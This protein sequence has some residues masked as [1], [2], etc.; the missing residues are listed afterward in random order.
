MG[1]RVVSTVGVPPGHRIGR[2]NGTM[3]ARVQPCSPPGR[4]SSI[5]ARLV[6]SEFCA[7]R[8]TT[9]VALYNG[10]VCMISNMHYFD[11]RPDYRELLTILAQPSHQPRVV[12]YVPITTDISAHCVCFLCAITNTT[13]YYLVFFLRS[14]LVTLLFSRLGC[15][16]FGV[17]E[18]RRASSAWTNTRRR[19]R[20]RKRRRRTT[21]EFVA[22]AGAEV[23]AMVKEEVPVKKAD[24]AT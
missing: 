23:T 14:L 20:R 17:R 1:V 7:R 15:G 5:V 18:P 13:I 19:K 3:C 10:L 6:C 4:V 9:G 21:T 2:S 16:T 22:S 24:E 12:M 8:R 11:V